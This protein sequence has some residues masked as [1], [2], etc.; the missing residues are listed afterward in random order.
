MYMSAFGSSCKPVIA[1]VTF[2]QLHTDELEMAT[3]WTLIFSS[4]LYKKLFYHFLQWEKGSS[5]LCMSLA[6]LNCFFIERI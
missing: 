1:V 2:Y 6:G 3:F 5:S 4:R